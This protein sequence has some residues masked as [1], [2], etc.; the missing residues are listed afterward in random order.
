[1]NITFTDKEEP[2]HINL[3]DKEQFD[4]AKSKGFLYAHLGIVK[5]GLDPLF[6]PYLNVSSLCCVLDTRHLEFPDA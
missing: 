2:I 6:M 5:L 3:I 1:M 4:W